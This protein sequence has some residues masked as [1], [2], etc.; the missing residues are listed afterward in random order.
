MMDSIRI[1]QVLMNLI[2]NAFKFTTKGSVTLYAEQ[3][4]GQDEVLIGVRDTGDGISPAEVENLFQRFQQVDKNQARRRMGTGLGLAI[5]RELVESHSG[6]I[7]VES[8][9]GEGSD[10]KFVL[11]LKT[12]EK[13]REREKI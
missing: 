1:N 13:N 3:V 12:P 2:S 4:S 5:S 8:T 6:R 9:L 11:P 10:F 7:W